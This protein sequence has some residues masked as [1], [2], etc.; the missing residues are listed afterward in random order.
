M[1]RFLASDHAGT[2]EQFATAYA[3]LARALGWP[4]RVVAGF[5]HGPVKDGT[6]AVTS[7]DAYA[8][9]D[10]SVAG[11]GWVP[12]DPTP[13]S[14]PTLTAP[15]ASPALVAPPVTDVGAP[16]PNATPQEAP[17]PAPEAASASTSPLLVA[18]LA[19]GALVLVG[20]VLLPLTV[21]A[22]RARRTR[23]RRRATNP[24]DRVLGAWRHAVG[25][26]RPPSERAPSSLTA[27]EWAGL[28]A[29]R[30]GDDLGA[31]LADLGALANQARFD[32]D[33]V[34]PADGPAAWAR[35]DAFRRAARRHLRLGTRLATAIDPRSLRRA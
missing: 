9:A 27:T 12:F 29:S 16:D 6:V 24:R 26:L 2:S 31:Q 4:T 7:A 15:P 3:L 33:Q 18:G 28:A 32:P 30:L 20:I 17:A 35:A 22:V 23:A 14:T 11:L 13:G 5:R 25:A 19:L 21:L 34:D 1:A 10:V 8:W